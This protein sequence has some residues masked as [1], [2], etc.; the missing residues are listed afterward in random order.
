MNKQSIYKIAI[1]NDLIGLELSNID[2]NNIL[3]PKAKLKL[4]NLKKS[5]DIF[6]EF[7]D[8]IFSHQEIQEAF[9]EYCDH[10]NEIIDEKLKILE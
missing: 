9:G 4:K 3:D 7:T 8:E 10:I 2:I 6:T 5:S 1:L